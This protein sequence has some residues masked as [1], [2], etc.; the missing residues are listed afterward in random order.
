MK[1]LVDGEG[2]DGKMFEDGRGPFLNVFVRLIKNRTQN[3]VRFM[4]K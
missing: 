2:R 3:V 1:V 4:F